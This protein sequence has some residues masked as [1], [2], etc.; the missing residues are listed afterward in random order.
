[1]LTTTEFPMSHRQRACSSLKSIFV[2]HQVWK[3]LEGPVKSFAYMLYGFSFKFPFCK[4]L[5][6]ADH[7]HSLT[8]HFLP[9][10]LLLAVFC[11]NTVC[12]IHGH[13]VTNFVMAYIM[14][15]MG[16]FKTTFEI[17]LASNN[18]TPCNTDTHT[19]VFFCCNIALAFLIIST[20]VL[21]LVGQM[22]G[23]EVKTHIHPILTVQ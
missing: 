19:N 14:Q 6:R 18:N 1:M 16:V 9:D 21:Q 15:C 20:N 2:V 22:D 23:R 10:L 5:S 12:A 4:T 7:T 11:N 13:P 17:S 8:L 3:M